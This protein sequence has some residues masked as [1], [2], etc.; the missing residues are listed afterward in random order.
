[1]GNPKK[2]LRRRRKLEGNSE[3]ILRKSQGNLKDI[4]RKS[5]GN[6]KER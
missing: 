5:K 3:E 6:P 1:M 4:L 2:I